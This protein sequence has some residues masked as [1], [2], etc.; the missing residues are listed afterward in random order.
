[1][2][3]EFTDKEKELLVELAADNLSYWQFECSCSEDY[4]REICAAIL[5][6]EKLDKDY[7]FHR[8][9]WISGKKMTIPEL[10]QDYLDS[11]KEWAA[12]AEGWMKNKYE[13]AIEYVEAFWA[14]HGCE[15]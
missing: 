6:L 8:Q 12:E 1:M 2:Q 7:I 11:L 4:Y 5:L 14:N 10:K 13:E 3:I 9:N 15:K